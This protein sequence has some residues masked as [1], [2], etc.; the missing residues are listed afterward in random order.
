MTDDTLYARSYIRA[1]YD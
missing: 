1:V